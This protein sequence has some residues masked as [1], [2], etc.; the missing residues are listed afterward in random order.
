MRV[1]SLG[2]L[3]ITGA[4]VAAACAGA[5]STAPSNAP[6]AGAPSTEPAPSTAPE[7][8]GAGIAASIKGFTLPDVTAAVGQEITW[9]NDDAAPHTVTTDDGAVD[10]RV[11]GGGGTFSHTFDAAG[12]Y[13]YHC[14]LHPS[15]KATIIIN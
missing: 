15:M 7:P 10:G 12:T 4:L 5:A 1:L 9:T 8:G 3:V 11:A 2:V 14:A 13:P 6:G